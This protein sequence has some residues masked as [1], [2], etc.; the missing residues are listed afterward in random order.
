MTR[1]DIEK[2]LSEKIANLKELEKIGK[3]SD[4]IKELSEMAFLQ[5][6][7]EQYENSETNFLICLKHFK[8]QFDRLGQAA[9]LGVLG[10]LYYRKAEYQ[11]SIEN[12]QD[13]L[14]TYKELNQNEELITCL[15]GIGSNYIKLK[16]LDEASEIFLECISICSNNND[17]YHL[18]DCIGN[19]IY[20]YESQEKWDIVLELYKKSLKAFKELKDKKGII[21]SYFN[22]GILE[23]KQNKYEKSLIYFKK[24]TNIAIEANYVEYI[25]KGLSYVGEVLMY[26]REFKEAKNQFIKALEYADKIKANNAIIQLKILLNSIGLSEKD[27]DNELKN[28]KIEKL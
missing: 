20:I 4:Y 12:Y 26:Q 10:T 17:I 25:L 16:L 22:L 5:L 24:G 8:K 19:L 1:E 27:I 18:L 21:V 7:I 13:A 2:T 28:Y 11:K 6:E 14:N 15:I 9:V 3:N 23:K